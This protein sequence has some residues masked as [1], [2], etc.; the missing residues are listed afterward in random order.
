MLIYWAGARALEALL[1]WRSAAFAKLGHVVQR[2]VVTYVLE[3]VVTSAA[4]GLA[5]LY[6]GDLL[7]NNRIGGVEN[8]VNL[9]VVLLLVG[10]LYLFVL[11]G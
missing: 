3:I 8:F 2:N 9:R 4:L 1:T 11:P 5:L 6:G 10:T 7:F